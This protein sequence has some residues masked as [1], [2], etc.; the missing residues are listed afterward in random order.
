MDEKGRPANEADQQVFAEPRDLPD[1]LAIGTDG[2]IVRHWPA[3]I[4]PR[5]A[6]DDAPV[7][8][9]SPQTEEDGFD[10]W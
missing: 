4:G 7:P 10:F 5:L 3:E 1:P 8:Q 2:E 9:G 6:A